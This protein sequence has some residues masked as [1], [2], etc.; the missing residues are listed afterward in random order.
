M[1]EHGLRLLPILLSDVATMP[2]N[3]SD[4]FFTERLRG[5]GAR[6]K[7]SRALRVRRVQEL[8][9]GVGQPRARPDDRSPLGPAWHVWGNCLPS[10]RRS[11]DLRTAVS[12]Y[13]RRRS[14]LYH[15]PN[16]RRPCSVGRRISR[17]C[18]HDPQGTIPVACHA[19]IRLQPRL[20]TRTSRRGDEEARGCIAPLLGGPVRQAGLKVRSR[21]GTMRCRQSGRAPLEPCFTRTAALSGRYT[22]SPRVMRKPAQRERCVCKTA[23]AVHEPLDSP[24][25]DPFVRDH[26]GS[27]RPCGRRCLLGFRSR[28]G[29]AEPACRGGAPDPQNIGSRDLAPEHDRSE[30]PRL[31]QNGGQQPLPLLRRQELS[32]AGVGA[33]CILPVETAAPA[34]STVLLAVE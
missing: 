10:P 11:R 26:M 6:A 20:P 28:R 18:S 29:V 23:G 21:C 17:R 2:P 25:R 34:M 27:R 30:D 16:R 32:V 1:A 24:T 19:R 7:L 14:R 9:H 4:Q 12:R 3:P 15:R 13:G 22:W 5:G 8:W 33:P 31:Q